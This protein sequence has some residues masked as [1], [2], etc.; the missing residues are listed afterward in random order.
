MQTFMISFALMMRQMSMSIVAP[1]LST[2][3]TTLSGYTTL[4]TGLT[5]GI[6]GLMQSI[7]QTPFG[8]LSDRFGHKKIMIIGLSITVIGLILAW[9]A[10]SIYVLIAARAFQGSGAIIGV[11]YAWA[12]GIAPVNKRSK[13]MGILTIM[14][15]GGAAAAFILGPVLREFLTVNQIFL[16]CALVIIVNIFYIIFFV[17]DQRG[18]KQEKK[19]SK[20]DLKKLLTNRY[21]MGVSF[22]AFLNNFMMMAIFFA[23]P[24][25]LTSFL[26]ETKLWITFIPVV[27]FAFF[28]MKIAVY[29]ADKSK[30]K[31][32]ML[33]AF[34]I[35]ALSSLLFLQK[36]TLVFLVLGITLFFG[37]YA[38]LAT[39]IASEINN[40]DI[41]DCRGT[42]NG[43]FNGLQFLGNFFGAVLMGLI[44]HYSETAG[45]SL[46]FCAGIIGFFLTVSLFIRRRK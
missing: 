17:P 44:W 36:E 9:K 21:F 43:V 1:F 19:D 39:V 12:A 11:G 3:C 26:P 2:Y 18:K 15:S 29:F 5:L 6:F 46:I 40:T 14:L 7:F 24:I 20:G 37:C 42:A 16:V 13:A 45:F 4:T 25:Y 28:S 31:Q 41:D 38:S 32:V 8:M 23:V 30:G 35:S 27:I 33:I 22:S 10:D 34:L